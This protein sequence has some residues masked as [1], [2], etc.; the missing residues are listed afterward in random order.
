MATVLCQRLLQWG[1]CVR[2]RFQTD[3]VVCDRKG[4][5]DS[6]DEHLTRTLRATAG[7]HQEK[8]V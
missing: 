6:L 1:H 4:Q 5:F 3:Y 2:R 7:Q 8:K